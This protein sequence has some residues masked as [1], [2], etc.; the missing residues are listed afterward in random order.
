M[1][2]LWEWSALQLTDNEA[3]LQPYHASCYTDADR[4]EQ[5]IIWLNQNPMKL[6]LHKATTERIKKEKEEKVIQSKNKNN[7]KGQKIKGRKKE[8]KW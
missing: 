8:K 7:I 1:S 6:K 2:T 3:Q 4:K 5:D